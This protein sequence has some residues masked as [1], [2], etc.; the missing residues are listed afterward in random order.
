MWFSFNPAVCFSIGHYS[1]P[2]P[3]YS[4]IDPA[5]S[6]RGVQLIYR[7]GIWDGQTKIVVLEFLC[8]PPVSINGA[9][10]TMTMAQAMAAPAS[11]FVCLID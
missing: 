2:Y 6:S 5:D 3:Q 1:D 7:N 9:A 4:L 11:A 8:E 10:A